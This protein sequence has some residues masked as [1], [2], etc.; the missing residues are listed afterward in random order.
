MMQKRQKMYVAVS[1]LVTIVAF[2]ADVPAAD[3]VNTFL[4]DVFSEFEANDILAWALYAV[5]LV[6]LIRGV[7]L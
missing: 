2:I 7:L 4:G 3:I 6:C 1:L 5:A